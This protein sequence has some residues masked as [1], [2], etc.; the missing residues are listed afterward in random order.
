[1]SHELH[2]IHFDPAHFPPEPMPC[3]RCG[4]T[5]PMAFRG[6]CPACTAE[7]HAKYQGEGR[8]VAG[9]AYEPAMHVTPN[10]VALKDD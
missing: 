3:L 2:A 4:E 6:T 10:A 7:L 1:M 5:A 8:E 9:A